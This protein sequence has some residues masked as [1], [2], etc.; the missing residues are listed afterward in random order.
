MLDSK[1]SRKTGRN[2]PLCTI[3]EKCRDIVDSGL[4]PDPCEAMEFSS[5]PGASSA[6]NELVE[7]K[8]P[9]QG[10]TEATP[11]AP[12]CALPYPD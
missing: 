6:A 1:S 5:A 7:D 2:L 9:P 11:L 12:I 3:K 4:H 10:L 8:R